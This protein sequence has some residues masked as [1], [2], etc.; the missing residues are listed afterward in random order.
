MAE[1]SLVGHHSEE[2][3]LVLWGFDAPVQGNARTGR[4]DVKYAVMFIEAFGEG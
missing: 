1:G 4:W 3:P 2:R